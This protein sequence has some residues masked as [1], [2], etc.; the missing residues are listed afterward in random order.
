M[1]NSKNKL[2]FQTCLLLVR[3]ITHLVEYE[4]NTGVRIG[5]HSRI[6]DSLLHPQEHFVCLGKSEKLSKDVQSRIEHIVPCAYM[7]ET[8][9]RLIKAKKY[10]EEELAHA[11][12]KN[13][14]VAHIT[15]EEAN[16]M[17]FNLKLKSVMPEDWDFMTGR[18]EVRL[19][20]AGIKLIP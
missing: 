6:F 14:K 10:T 3:H 16:F 7:I 11:L 1:D 19:E 5:Y 2:I 4:K 12:Q 13:W 18:P 9:E 8:L 17:D 20:L 15:K